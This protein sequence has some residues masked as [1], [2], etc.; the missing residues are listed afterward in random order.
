M[1][2][3]TTYALAILIASALLATACGPKQAVA[4]TGDGATVT[5]DATAP[6]APADTAPS[7][8]LHPASAPALVYFARDEKVAACYRKVATP[9]VARGA[10]L[11][12][13]KGPNAAEKTAGMTSAIPAGTR[14]LGLDVAGG[15][16]TVDLTGE[17]DDGGGTL[18]MSMRVAQVVHTLTQFSTVERVSFRMDGAPLTV[19]G[20]EGLLIGEPQTR[21]GWGDYAPAVLIEHPAFGERPSSPLRVSGTA[22]VFE[23]VFRLEL[24]GPG[25]TVLASPVVQASSG[26]GTRGTFSTSIAYSPWVHGTG[27]LTAWYESPKDG[28]R[29][30][31]YSVPLTLEP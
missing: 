21:A 14:L 6:P 12:L 25:G 18:S 28:S 9:A 20:G 30:D 3:T 5:P 1:S 19:L 24:T 31:V 16:A 2:R 17:F 8:G 4:P 13:L 7:G 23:A 22:N 11:E 29:V 10:M 26:T 27:E 15:T